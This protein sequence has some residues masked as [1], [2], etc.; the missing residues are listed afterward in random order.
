MTHESEREKDDFQTYLNSLK[1]TALF[2]KCNH[3][4]SLHDFAKKKSFTIQN[5]EQ[6]DS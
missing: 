4:E 2:T 6:M 3:K 5:V 1:G